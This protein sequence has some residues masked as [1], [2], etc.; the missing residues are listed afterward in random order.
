M[1][2]RDMSS[3]HLCLA[4]T[5]IVANDNENASSIRRQP[6]FHLHK[7]FVESW[8][9]AGRRVISAD[10]GKERWLLTYHVGAGRSEG[11]NRVR[12]HRVSCS[13]ETTLR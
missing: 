8:R 6:E 13:D 11:A 12:A 5:V 3:F 7:V 1:T 9:I 10:A 2:S 4:A